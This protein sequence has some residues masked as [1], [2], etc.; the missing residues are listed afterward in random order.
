MMATKIDFFQYGVVILFN[1]VL[2]L[3][4]SS[5]TVSDTWL[6]QHPIARQLRL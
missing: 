4:K 2:S 5:C 1:F 6:H 3:L